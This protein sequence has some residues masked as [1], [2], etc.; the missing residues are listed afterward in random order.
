MPEP[1]PSRQQELLAGSSDLV[2]ERRA[3]GAVCGCL[4]QILS[5]PSAEPCR[6]VKSNT[7]FLLLSIFFIISG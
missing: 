4:W 6:T 5:W 7:K 2:G 1:A 3:P